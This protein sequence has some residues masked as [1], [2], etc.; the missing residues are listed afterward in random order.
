M[1]AGG[2]ELDG[3]RILR[4]ESVRELFRQQEGAGRRTLGWVAFCPE[5]EPDAAVP[6][7]EPV[8]YGHTGWSGASLWMEGDGGVWAVLLTNRS[9]DVRAESRMGWLRAELFRSLAGPASP[10]SRRQESGGIRDE[11]ATRQGGG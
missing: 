4:P 2:G 6:C 5:E 7:E 9:Y 3:V 10:A 11:A 1:I 8:A